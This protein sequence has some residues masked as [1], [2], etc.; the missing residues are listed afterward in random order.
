M[1][2]LSRVVG[3]YHCMVSF[4]V[5][6]YRCL[7]VGPRQGHVRVGHAMLC[8]NEGFIPQ[9]AMRWLCFDLVDLAPESIFQRQEKQISAIAKVSARPF[10]HPTHAHTHK[11]VS[12]YQSYH[13][14]VAIYQLMSCRSSRAVQL[15]CLG[16]QALKCKQSMKTGSTIKCF[17]FQIT[18]KIASKFIQLWGPSKT[19]L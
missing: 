13:I 8:M 9:H 11:S 19:Y 14:G 16:P 3:C 10:G 17:A 1:M 6:S 15:L 5:G 12:S 2:V 18:K 4:S 7:F